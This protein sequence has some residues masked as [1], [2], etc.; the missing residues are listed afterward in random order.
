MMQVQ[1]CRSAWLKLCKQVRFCVR[2]LHALGIFVAAKS[3]TSRMVQRYL[4]MLGT[5]CSLG[6]ALGSQW[7]DIF[8]T[9]LWGGVNVIFS[10]REY[11]FIWMIIELFFYWPSK[12]L[13]AQR[14]DLD[15]DLAF[16]RQGHNHWNTESRHLGSQM[17]FDN[18]IR[19][20]KNVATHLEDTRK[21]IH[22]ARVK[23]WL[24]LV[25]RQGAQLEQRKSTSSSSIRWLQLSTL[26]CVEKFGQKLTTAS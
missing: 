3:R 6:E 15:V 8:Y 2:F 19:I 12:Y 26:A 16:F 20:L 14:L 21:F 4:C 11:E 22:S 1:P 25:K 23:L 17:H 24:A 9:R 5:L 18:N 7:F 13:I 10:A